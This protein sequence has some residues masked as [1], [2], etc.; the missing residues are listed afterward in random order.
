MI[1]QILGNELSRLGI[2][3]RVITVITQVVVDPR[4]E[5]FSN[6]TKP[7]G[8]YYPEAV[9]RHLMEGKGWRMVEDRGRGGFRRLVASPRP[10]GIVEKESIRRILAGGDGHD[11]VIAAGGGGVPVVAHQGGFKGIEAV[12][13]K[14]LASSVLARDIGAELLAIV[15][16]VP[17]VALDW[18]KPTQRFITS[19]TVAEAE[20]Y[21]AEGHFPP[22][23]MGPK[24]DAAIRFV[25]KGHG[26]ALITDINSLDEALMGRAG[27]Q[28]R[29]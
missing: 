14:D 19:L 5:A 13:D 7:I 27:T 21:M 8:P 4:D 2:A 28:I 15:T 10:L 6:P 16:D 17:A 26:R 22:G 11:V 12:I 3:S 18:G 20:S 1:Q 29:S 24:V 25:R 9:A 23:S